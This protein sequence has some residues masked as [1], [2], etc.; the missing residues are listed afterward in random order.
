MYA[1]TVLAVAILTSWVS[2][3]QP[4][5]PTRVFQSFPLLTEVDY[6]KMALDPFGARMSAGTCVISAAQKTKAWL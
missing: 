6:N 5:G 1:L 3:P 2:K 4:L